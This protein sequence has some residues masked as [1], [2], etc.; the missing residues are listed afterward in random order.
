MTARAVAAAKGDTGAG[1][2]LAHGRPSTPSQACSQ[3]GQPP[4]RQPVSSMATCSACRV[5]ATSS[6]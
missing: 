2:P 1:H 4:T 5:A 6:A 3:A